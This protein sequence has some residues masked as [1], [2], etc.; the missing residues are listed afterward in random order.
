MVAVPVGGS[1]DAEETGG[2]FRLP[3]E[4]DAEEEVGGSVCEKLRFLADRRPSPPPAGDD[5]DDAINRPSPR[6]LPRPGCLFR[7]ASLVGRPAADPLA[8]KEGEAAGFEAYRPNT[9]PPLHTF[10]TGMSVAPEPRKEPCATASS[11]T[12]TASTAHTAAAA[13]ADAWPWPGAAAPPVRAKVYVNHLW[14]LANQ[15]SPYPV[16]TCH[17]HGLPHFFRDPDAPPPPATGPAPAPAAPGLARRCIYAVHPYARRLEEEAR[18]RDI[19]A[20]RLLTQAYNERPPRIRAMF[21]ETPQG[22]AIRAL[23]R[24]AHRRLYGRG[25]LGCLKRRRK[26]WLTTGDALLRLVR[27]AGGTPVPCTTPSEPAEKAARKGYGAVRGPEFTYTLLEDGVLHFSGAGSVALELPSKHCVHSCAAPHVI[28]SG[29]FRLEER[30]GRRTVLVM[31]NDSGTYAPTNARGELR[32][33]QGLMAWNFPGLHVETRSY[34]PAALDQ[35]SPE[36]H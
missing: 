6:L 34:T 18:L 9:P 4:L 20:T 25:W 1:D 13:A 12:A 24:A 5:D 15:L 19:L 3:P 29:T 14:T 31:D 32:R 35:D 28:Y 10:A 30:D 23:A 22:A 26:A 2:R 8:T 33:L 7:C 27:D 11:P 17:L 21:A 36:N 16:H